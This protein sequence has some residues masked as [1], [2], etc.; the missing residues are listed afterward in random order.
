MEDTPFTFWASPP[1]EKIGEDASSTQNS[2]KDA[3]SLESLDVSMDY[4]RTRS[5]KE[6]AIRREILSRV[7]S[8]VRRRFYWRI[9]Q[10]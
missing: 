7:T 5:S 1:S 9:Q 3:M 8:L 6:E 2:T 10:N 4:S